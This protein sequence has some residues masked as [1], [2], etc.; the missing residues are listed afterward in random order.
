MARLRSER[1]R[2]TRVRQTRVPELLPPIPGRLDQRS[3]GLFAGAAVVTVLVHWLIFQS[4]Y[5]V[6]PLC[7][8]CLTVWAA[9]I[10]G[11]L[12]GIRFGTVADAIGMRL[13]R[14]RAVMRSTNDTVVLIVGIVAILI[15]VAIW[16]FRR[17]TE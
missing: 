1:E 15:A 14:V 3:V 8:Y 13:Q 12:N 11:V 6:E 17:A 2:S 10:A 9:T 16:D 4:L 7:A 5:R